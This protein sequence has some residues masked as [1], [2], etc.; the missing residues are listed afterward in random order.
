[1]ADFNGGSIGK[2]GLVHSGGYVREE[3]HR[4]LQGRNWYLAA[5]E[6]R[7]NN[8]TISTS[9]RLISSL[10]QGVKWHAEPAECPHEVNQDAHEARAEHEAQY[11][12]SVHDDM[13]SP[14][15]KSVGTT[16]DDGLTFGFAPQEIIHKIRR[17]PNESDR[18]FRSKYS[19]GRFGI[20]ELGTRAPESTYKWEIDE[21]TDRALLWKVYARTVV[22]KITWTDPADA[23]DPKLRF[24]QQLKAETREKNAVTL[25]QRVPKFFE[26]IQRVAR[27]W[28]QYR[29]AHEEDAAGN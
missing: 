29:A 4:R 26:G 16:V 9:I 13:D 28:S 22:T 10:L 5:R 24:H 19:D 6:M 18:A 12:E 17:G 2:F 21:D 25:F 11:L 15:R 1:M 3:F 7:E 20:R 27:Q 8:A 14:F 23:K